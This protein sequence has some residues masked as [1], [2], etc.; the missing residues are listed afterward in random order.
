MGSDLAE[1]NRTLI[2]ISDICIVITEPNLN[3]CRKLEKIVMNQDVFNATKSLTI[4][5]HIRTDGI[6]LNADG[7]FGSISAYNSVEAAMEDPLFYRL[8]LEITE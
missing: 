4:S 2:S 1:T 6:H 5:N 3:A 8:A 7:L